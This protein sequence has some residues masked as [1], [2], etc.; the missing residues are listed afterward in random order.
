[1]EAPNVGFTPAPPFDR[2]LIFFG[3]NE[4]RGFRWVLCM[5]TYLLDCQCG[6]RLPV[7]IGQAGGRIT[8]SCGK[9]V[10]VPTLRNLRHLPTAEVEDTQAKRASVPWNKRK[11]A[12]AACLIVFSVFAVVG[13]WNR[14]RQPSIPKFDPS[15]RLRSV[16]QQLKTIT[17]ADAF[18]LSQ[19]YRLLAEHGL[20]VFEVANQAAI[21][22]QIRHQ[23]FQRRIYWIIAAIFAA[24][25]ATI[26][27]WPRPQPISR[28]SD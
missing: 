22:Q 2:G 10:D 7:E 17:P 4:L 12:I 13:I 25:A 16:E 26:Y 15:A 18:I 11:G 9:E 28:R 6:Q 19:N 5:T 21:E 24:A 1:V 3:A 27:F 8:C 23:Q 14:L 20:S